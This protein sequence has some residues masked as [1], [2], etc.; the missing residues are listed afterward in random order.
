MTVYLL[1]MLVQTSIPVKVIFKWQYVCSFILLLK[2]LPLRLFYLS[3]W[4][5]WIWHAKQHFIFIHFPRSPMY[6]SPFHIA[7]LENK[8][9]PKNSLK[10]RLPWSRWKVNLYAFFHSKSG[11]DDHHYMLFIYLVFRW[12]STRSQALGNNRYV[13]KPRKH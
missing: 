1:S 4:I 2:W 9:V 13:K 10:C 12:H 5:S 8:T 11:I 6:W 7:Q 3:R